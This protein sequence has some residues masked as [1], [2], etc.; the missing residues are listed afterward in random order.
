MKRASTSCGNFEWY[1]IHV[2]GV[3]EGTMGTEEI[4]EDL[5]EMNFSDLYTHRQTHTHTHNIII[6]FKN[7]IGTTTLESSMEIY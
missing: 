3:P 6:K 7:F 1:N 5:M 2:I 4:F